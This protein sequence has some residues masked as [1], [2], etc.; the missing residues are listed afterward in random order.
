M[1][2][3]IWLAL[4]ALW[5]QVAQK[6]HALPYM[7]PSERELLN[8]LDSLQRFGAQMQRAQ[9][10]QRYL[11]ALRLEIEARKARY[12]RKLLATQ[13]T[14]RKLQATPGAIAPPELVADIR[15]LESE[16]PAIREM[17][18]RFVHYTAIYEQLVQRLPKVQGERCGY[19]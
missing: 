8:K 6:R 2:W 1:P 10:A 19:V 16:L 13:A 15:W 14:I 4:S 9:A 18:D 12:E 7:S 17:V 5:A 11:E 3:W